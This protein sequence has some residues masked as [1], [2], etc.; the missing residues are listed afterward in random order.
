MKELI[1]RK[2][3]DA[4]L[5]RTS[6]HLLLIL[7]GVAFFGA[8]IPKNENK[9]APEEVVKEVMASQLAAWNMG[10]AIGFM[11]GYWK[12]DSLLFCTAKGIIN[13][14]S[15]VLAMYQR[16]YDTKEKMG[17]L[18]FDIHQISPKPGNTFG[19]YGAWRVVNKDTSEGRFV[20]TFAQKPQQGW[21]IV[22]DHT[23]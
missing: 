16:S 5:L 1:R 17:H 23:W 9:I 4:A 18:D 21:C 8:C 14:H 11:N 3:I 2:L 22:E 20:L 6:L 10:D 12:S 19:V 13:G 7:M 15:K